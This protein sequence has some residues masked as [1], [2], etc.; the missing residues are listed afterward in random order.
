[1]VKK[2]LKIFLVL[3]III[4]LFMPFISVNASEAQK[5]DLRCPIGSNNCQEIKDKNGNVVE[6][7]VT[8]RES[9]PD[10][11]Y[12]EIVKIVKKTNVLGEFTVSFK[13]SGSEIVTVGQKEKA[14]VMLIADTSSSLSKTVFNVLKSAAVQFSKQLT[15][16]NIYFALDQFATENSFRRDFKKKA[17]SDNDFCATGG[18]GMKSK[19]YLGKALKFANDKFKNLDS[20]QKFVVMFGDGQYWYSPHTDWSEVKKWNNK[21]NEQGVRQFAIQ[22]KDSDY[23]QETGY[24]AC[25]KYGM[26]T[27]GTCDTYYF[28]QLT[29]KGD[30]YFAATTGDYATIFKQIADK[31]IGTIP[32]TYYYSAELKDYLGEFFYEKSTNKITKTFQID[33]ITKEGVTTTPFT[34]YI[35]SNTGDGWHDTNASFTLSY[36]D[37]DNKEKNITCDEN[38]EVYWVGDRTTINSCSGSIP[39]KKSLISSST[40]YYTKNC[41]EGYTKNG[42]SYN[43]V[44]VFINVN[45][46]D[47]GTKK[48]N[49]KSGLGFPSSIKLSTNVLCNYEFLSDKYNQDLNNVL[50]KLKSETNPREIASL[51]LQK[52]ELEKVPNQYNEMISA[53]LKAYLERFKKQNATLKVEYADLNKAEISNYIDNGEMISN[54]VCSTIETKMV[55]GTSLKTKAECQL[56]MSKNMILPEI[57]LNM[58]TGEVAT[59]S[60]LKYQI[61]GYN[62]FYVDLKSKGGQIFVEVSNLGI[63]S[64]LTVKLDDCS[65]DTLDLDLIYRQIENSDPFLQTYTEPQRE[66]PKN[67]LNNKYNFVDIIKADIWDKKFNYR[68]SLSKVNVDNIKNDTNTIGSDAYLGSD[69][70]INSNYKYVCRFLSIKENNHD[71]FT[72]VESSNS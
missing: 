33:K 19:S 47:D 6:V 54:L 11:N 70:Y 71:F 25:T 7:R 65:F 13:V 52:E 28:S 42:V 14:Y 34:I 68:F 41:Q 50:E 39:P 36:I 44:S 56:S 59:C 20:T 21:L 22:F 30:F 26:K 51:T 24:N 48:F 29:K 64:N 12:I 15:D 8:K 45:N 58:Q 38:P 32:T 9:L 53:E 62:K 43:G 35:D 27:Y 16:E 55:A 40:K 67:Y 3:V 18:C 66:I 57:C 72:K 23:Y 60:D 31:I 4:S 1:M 63:Q 5:G 37:T 46:L 61:Q 17:I 10:N 49:I 2:N 69:C